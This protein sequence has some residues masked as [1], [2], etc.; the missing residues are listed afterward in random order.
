MQKGVK[1][2][3]KVVLLAERNS[4]KKLDTMHGSKPFHIMFACQALLAILDGSLRMKRAPKVVILL[5]SLDTQVRLPVY[6]KLSQIF[7]S[8]KKTRPFRS[9]FHGLLKLLAIQLKS[10]KRVLNIQKCTHMETTYCV[11]IGYFRFEGTHFLNSSQLGHQVI[12]SHVS[13]STFYPICPNASVPFNEKQ[14]GFLSFWIRNLLHNADDIS[15]YN[16]VLLE[17]G[18]PD[19]KFLN[20]IF[21]VKGHHQI[22]L[23]HQ[24][25][26][27]GFRYFF[28]HQINLS[29]GFPYSHR[30]NLSP[31]F[32][33][34]SKINLSPGFPLLPL[35]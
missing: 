1:R 19:K 11:T 27:Q 15:W 12:R 33:L 24:S 6:S 31:G 9:H 35:D 5:W 23:I 32:P 28:S 8:I 17:K 26:H 13:T 10:S 30:I 3:Q 14:M 2:A 29:P 7:H 21:G 20:N 4:A 22:N 25:S 18:E 16:L 34:L